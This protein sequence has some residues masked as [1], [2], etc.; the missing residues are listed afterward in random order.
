MDD[1]PEAL[2]ESPF[3]REA[4]VFFGAFPSAA[5]FASRAAFD[6]ETMLW[7]VG[8]VEELV[9]AVSGLDGCQDGDVRLEGRITVQR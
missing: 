4:A 5:R 7:C 8:C 3:A 1:A 9:M 2:A 6:A